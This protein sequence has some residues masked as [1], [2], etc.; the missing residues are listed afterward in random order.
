MSTDSLMG[1]NEISSIVNTLMYFLKIDYKNQVL[2]NDNR[3]ISGR[4]AQITA[5]GKQIGVSVSSSSSIRKLGLCNANSSF[6][7]LI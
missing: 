5:G 7:K 4:C 6:V 3:F 2:E 1:Y